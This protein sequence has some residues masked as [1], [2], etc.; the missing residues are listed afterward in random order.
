MNFL[1]LPFPQI[2]PVM[3]QLGPLSIHWYGV[4]YVVGILF[5]WWYARRLAADPRLWGAGG[6]PMT[7]EDI[8]D[9]L[10][11]AVVGIIAGGRIGYILFYD[12]PV[13]LD[14][15]LRVF[16]LWAGG[17]SFH[18]G[19]A[20]TVVAMILYARRRGFSPWSLFDVIAASIGLGLFLGRLA[21]FIN[22]E[23]WGKVTT[24]PWGVV[25]PAAGPE[26]RHPTQ[27]YEAALEGI[28]LFVLLRVLT[29]GFGQLR[30]PG[31][32]AG[33]FIAWYAACRILVEFFRLPDAQ[34]GY[35]AGGWLTMG[36]VL[37]LPMAAL[38]LWAMATAKGR[39][40]Q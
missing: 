27:L 37:S 25:F 36:M 26:P 13:Y 28:G 14:D 38:G 21:N 17:M 2:D 29:H 19:L 39:A 18:G 15:P 1:A 6:S 16:Q 23:L 4:A 22:Q 3:L 12:L 31:F 10:V 9:F 34:L 20:G 40:P 5:G 35:L 24:L 11:W 32:V 8:D 7:V 33:A 30:N